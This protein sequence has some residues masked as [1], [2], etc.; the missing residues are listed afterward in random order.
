MAVTPQIIRKSGTAERHLFMW[1]SCLACPLWLTSTLI[2]DPEGNNSQTICSKPLYP[3]QGSSPALS[4]FVLRGTY[5]EVRR[6]NKSSPN[7]IQANVHIFFVAGEP[8]KERRRCP[9]NLNNRTPE[10]AATAQTI[11]PS[12]TDEGSREGS[13]PPTTSCLWI[14]TAT[15]AVGSV[16]DGGHECQ[17]TPWK[18]LLSQDGV[19]KLIR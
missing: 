8:P 1:H 18:L 4:F 11:P 10:G 15:P 9:L 7:V 5:V 2:S 19:S 16:A 6:R 17:S 13:T 3:R 14:R 12:G